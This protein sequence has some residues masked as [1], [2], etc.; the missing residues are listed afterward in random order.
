MSRIRDWNKKFNSQCR[1]PFSK[2][3]NCNNKFSNWDSNKLKKNVRVNKPK[4]NSTR[5]PPHSSN[6]KMSTRNSSYSTMSKLSW[7]TSTANLYC[8]KNKTSPSSSITSSYRPNSRRRKTKNINSKPNSFNSR[9]RSDSTAPKLISTK[10]NS[11]P[12]SRKY[13]KYK[14]ITSVL[15][16]KPIQHSIKNSPG[17]KNSTNPP[18]SY[19]NS[20]I[21]SRDN[22]WVILL[23]SPKPANSDSINSKMDKHLIYIQNLTQV[24]RKEPIL[25]PKKLELSPRTKNF[26]LNLMKMKKSTLNS[27]N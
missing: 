1:C 11:L 2:S 8:Y 25:H 7:K 18:S 12:L 13:N 23:N 27:I 14:R 20:S 24:R 17:K 21:E 22:L 19:R 16:I 9:K 5:K 10:V 4:T 26:S 6:S 15:K 3:Y